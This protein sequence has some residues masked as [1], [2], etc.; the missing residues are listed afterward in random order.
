MLC[1]ILG[2]MLFYLMVMLFQLRTVL[3]KEELGKGFILLIF[4]IIILG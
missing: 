2:K 1:E 4:V 3:I